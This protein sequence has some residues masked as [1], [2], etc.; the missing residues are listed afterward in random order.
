MLKS[1]GNIKVSPWETWLQDL[2]WS[3]LGAHKPAPFPGGGGNPWRGEIIRKEKKKRAWGWTA[4][5]VEPW[6]RR[7]FIARRHGLR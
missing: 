5:A 6:C 3:P 1:R 2:V 7:H 4:P